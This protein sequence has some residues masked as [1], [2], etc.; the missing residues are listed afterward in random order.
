MEEFAEIE[1]HGVKIEFTPRENGSCVAS[2]M[3]SSSGSF[4]LVV[5]RFIRTIGVIVNDNEEVLEMDADWN[6]PFRRTRC[7]YLVSD[8]EG[9]FGRI[10]PFCKKYFRTNCLKKKLI[11]PYCSISGDNGVFTTE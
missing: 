10:C 11:C 3:P 5:N 9:L 8:R 2:M 7:T 4:P 6:S 1:P